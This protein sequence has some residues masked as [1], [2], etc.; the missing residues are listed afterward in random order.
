M[1]QVL[2]WTQLEGLSM[3][4]LALAVAAVH[5]LVDVG[6]A[7]ALAGVAEFFGTAGVTDIEICDEQMGRLILFVFRAGEIHVGDFVERE[8]S[9]HLHR[10]RRRR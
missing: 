6:G 5:H 2:Q 3:Q 10:T 7:K 1:S 9:I 4:L 8:L